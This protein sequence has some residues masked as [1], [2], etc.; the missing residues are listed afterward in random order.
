MRKATSSRLAAVGITAGVIGAAM[1]P[2]AAVAQPNAPVAPVGP[3]SVHAAKG[4]PQLSP[5]KAVEQIRQV[6]KCGNRMYAVGSFSRISQGAKIYTRH[7]VF[8]FKA[9]RP[10]TVTPW[11]P[12]VKGE[13]DTIAFN[14]NHC[15]TAYLG[16]NFTKIGKHTVANLAEVKTNHTGALIKKFKAQPDREVATLMVWK[17]HLFAGGFFLTINGSTKH[18]YFASLR[19]KTGKDDGYLSLHISG[20]YVYKSPR[21][22]EVVENPTRIFKMQ[23]NHA[24]DHLLVEG[25]FLKIGHRARQ[26]I[27]MLTLG[28]KHAKT[29]KWYP[30]EFNRKCAAN[31]PFY[32]QD[33]AWSVND[34]Q[35]FVA[36]TGG[37][38]NKGPGFLASQPR[39]GLCDAASAFPAKQH[40]VKHQWINYTGCDSLF[41]V[42][43][44]KSTVYIGGHERWVNNSQGCDVMGSGAKNAQGMAGLG[45]SHGRLTYNPTRSRGF[46][47]DDML[48]TQRG[49]WVASDNFDD[50][51]QCGHD[52]DHAGLCYLPYKK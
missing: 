10:Y 5:T 8:S 17:N 44:D 4:T 45:P 51:V 27:A 1:M 6:A 52:F 33:A 14:G 3:A 46:G 29:S 18:K 35:V 12:N 24:G 37:A 15:K 49:L 11:H 43:A 20:N 30:K 13:V 42:A 41:S 16:G 47:A 40:K 25:D 32:A 36:T 50:A 48:L 19:P 28:P 9:T 2:G 34:K 23:L 22:H 31:Q 38:P 21:G 39:S 26:Q 7:N